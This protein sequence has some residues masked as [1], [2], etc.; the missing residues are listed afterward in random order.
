MLDMRVYCSNQQLL[1]QG[2]IRRLTL[3][4]AELRLRWGWQGKIQERDGCESVA[5]ILRCRQ[6]HVIGNYIIY[7]GYNFSYFTGMDE[8]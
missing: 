8:L 5:K 7:Q 4:S 2:I 1:G 6:D 3:A